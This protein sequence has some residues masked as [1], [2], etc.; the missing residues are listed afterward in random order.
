ML[1]SKLNLRSRAALRQT[2][3]VLYV[4][5]TKQCFDSQAIRKMSMEGFCFRILNHVFLIIHLPPLKHPDGPKGSQ[6]PPFYNLVHRLLSS[7]HRTSRIFDTEYYNLVF[8][9]QYLH[10]NT[11]KVFIYLFTHL[12]INLP[13]D[14][15]NL[16]V[17]CLSTTA[18]M[19]STLM[20]WWRV[21]G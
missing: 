13:C 12:S 21:R 20:G 11:H 6:G 8:I 15:S 5:M 18:P 10:T 3:T 2:T 1:A 16:F 9:R 17:G 4:R 19:W 7:I 14:W